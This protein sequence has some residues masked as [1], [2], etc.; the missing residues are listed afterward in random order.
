MVG[1]VP[2]IQLNDGNRMPAIGLGTCA[3]SSVKNTLK[4]IQI[5]PIMIIFQSNGNEIERAVEDA[6]DVGYRQIDTA[7]A[8]ENE[9]AIGKAVRAKIS[10]G[11]ITRSDMFI[12]TKVS[13]I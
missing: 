10:E 2:Y 9:A 13:L 11:V 3:V 8:Y 5:I 4:M 1:N 7:W 12:V 6:I